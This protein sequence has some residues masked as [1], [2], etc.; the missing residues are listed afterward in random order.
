MTNQSVIQEGCGCQ[1]CREGIS[2]ARLH[3]LLK[4]GNPIAAELITQHNIAYMMSLVRSMRMAV[5]EDRFPQ[6]ARTFVGD[7]FPGKDKGGEDCPNWV[8]EALEA[9]GVAVD[10]TDG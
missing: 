7:Q 2:R 9:A 10:V 5:L 1:P 3:S 4:A 8:T 6:F